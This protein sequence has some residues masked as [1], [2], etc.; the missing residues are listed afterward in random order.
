[1][2]IV[3]VSSQ[4]SPKKHDPSPIACKA[5]CGELDERLQLA[6]GTATYAYINDGYAARFTIN[7]QQVAADQM[8]TVLRSQFQNAYTV[9]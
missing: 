3:T 8:T 1:M 5:A 7:N 2:P 6:G 9:I 4:N